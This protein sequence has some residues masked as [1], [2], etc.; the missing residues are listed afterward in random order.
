M[1][2]NRLLLVEGDAVLRDILVEQLA[3]A[4]DIDVTACERGGLGRA[5]VRDEPYEIVLA[6]AILPD[7]EG[8]DFVAG[9]REDG[10]R[11]PVIRL[12]P[13]GS[14]GDPEGLDAGA[15]EC[16]VRPFKVALLLARIRAQIRAHEA[17]EEAAVP[18][19]PYTFRAG[20]KTLTSETGGVLR[21]TEKEVAILRFLQRAGEGIVSR[22][23]LLQEVWGYN[24]SVTTHTLETHIYRLRQKIETDPS[25]ARIL[26]TEPGGYR[27]MA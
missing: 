25:E 7:M 2:A 11:G 10:F 3:P 6:D 21:L 5:A 8:R 14:D 16:V 9:I 12:A 18:I 4:S 17:S 19:G 23:T 13:P 22:D 27:L 24:A 20:A 26:V 1:S 15:N